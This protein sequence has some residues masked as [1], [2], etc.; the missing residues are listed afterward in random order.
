MGG[1]T[2]RARPL[3]LA[4]QGGGAF[5]AFTW[6]VLD[7]L[8]E[9]SSIRFDTI[10]G[11]SAGAINAVLLADGLAEGGREAARAKLALFWRDIG[12]AAPSRLAT[13]LS[14]AASV[15]SLN[16]GPIASPYQLNPLGLNPLRT[17]LAKA[18]DFERLRRDPKVG[19]LIAA[20]RVKDGTLRLF[21]A[22]EVTVDAVLASSCLPYL[23]HAV[24]IDGEAYWDGAFTANPP[25]RGLALE[26]AAPE[27]LLVQIAPDILGEAPHTAGGI[28]RR[29]NEIAF[30]TSLQR[31]RQALDDLRHAAPEGVPVLHQIDAT[32]WVPGLAGEDPIHPTTELLERLFARGRRAGGEFL[33]QTATE[34]ARG[35]RKLFG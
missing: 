13:L 2:V 33:S 30:A 8:L 22:G 4:L 21:R 23:N 6:G 29:I 10:S 26:S 24:M 32:D 12:S 34:P 18:V 27:M 11:A 17:A 14:Q 19:L 25:L 28:S 3:S 20:T 15:V 9:D 7:R 16:P 35:L 31:E 5:G 1:L